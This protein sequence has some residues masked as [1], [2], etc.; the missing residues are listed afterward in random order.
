MHPTGVSPRLEGFTQSGA[1]PHPGTGEKEIG[2][3]SF[4]LFVQM[5]PNIL[6]FTEL[7]LLV[8]PANSSPKTADSYLSYNAAP[9]N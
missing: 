3:T 6:H 2:S 7:F 8:K 1:I 4:K 5:K 9:W